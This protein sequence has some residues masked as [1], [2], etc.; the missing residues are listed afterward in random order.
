MFQ[1]G[2]LLKPFMTCLG[3]S[4]TMMLYPCSATKSSRKKKK[5]SKTKIDTSQD[6]NTRALEFVNR[7]IPVAD[8]I[9]G[10]EVAK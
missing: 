4:S 8:A 7:G 5:S 2:I 10:T 3:W 9:K 1:R 6:N